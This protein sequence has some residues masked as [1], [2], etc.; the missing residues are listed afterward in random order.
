M[1]NLFL[2]VG[3]AIL[4]PVSTAAQTTLDPMESSPSVQSRLS[5]RDSS[6][7][8]AGRE[9]GP[10]ST[11]QPQGLTETVKG[12]LI[13]AGTGAG[14]GIGLGLYFCDGAH[15]YVSGYVKDALIFG[16]IG[17]GLGALIG[18][19]VDHSRRGAG[20]PSKTGPNVA[21]SP[22]LSQSV[23]GGLVAVRF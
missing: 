1:R 13:G 23:R 9:A 6:N 17:A 12:V 16:G 2:A 21:I 14:V 20:L 4:L 3:L 8:L 11:G 19:V 15:C 7:I 18:S 5:P 10:Q 22:V